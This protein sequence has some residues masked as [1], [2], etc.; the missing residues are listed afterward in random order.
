MGIIYFFHLQIGEETFPL[1]NIGN[2]IP[3]FPLPYDVPLTP[4]GPDDKPFVAEDVS[5]DSSEE[6]PEE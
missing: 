1:E 5:E 3:P 2:N 6:E 4:Y